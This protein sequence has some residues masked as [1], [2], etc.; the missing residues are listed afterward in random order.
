MAETTTLGVILMAKV[1][2][3]D[4]KEQFVELRAKG[5]SYDEI[6]KEIGVS[7]PTLI[8]WGKEMQM[9]ISNRKALELE[10]L[11][12]KYFV[13]KAKRIELFGEE[14]LRLNEEL[15]KRNLSEVPT[16]KLFDMKMKTIASLKQE[17]TETILREKSSLDNSLTE[18][19]ENSYTEWKA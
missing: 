12:E 17:E 4:Q 9:D 2:K 19:L 15:T 6:S 1:T 10:L 8:K 13:S 5:V 7:K 18:L 16:E 11:Q 14:L 3:I